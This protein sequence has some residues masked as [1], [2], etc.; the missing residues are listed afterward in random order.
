MPAGEAV[1]IMD[2]PQPDAP[3]SDAQREPW[4]EEPE[5]EEDPDKPK[6]VEGAAIPFTHPPSQQQL[7][8]AMH[9]KLARRLGGG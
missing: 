1:L 8:G 4:Y 3:A 6:P 5:E 7:Q 2:Q 9:A